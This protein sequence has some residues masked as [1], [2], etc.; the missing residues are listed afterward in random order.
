MEKVIL[1]IE[2]TSADI[3]LLYTI[4]RDEKIDVEQLVRRFIIEGIN[5]MALARAPVGPSGTSTK[6]GK[7]GGE[8]K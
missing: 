4:A 8:N 3:A 1:C 2:L 7:K 6:K 5:N